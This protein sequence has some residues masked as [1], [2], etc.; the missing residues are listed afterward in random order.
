MWLRCK[1]REK[2]LNQNLA[3]QQERYNVLNQR[4][5]DQQ[6]RYNVLQ[7]EF[8]QF[9]SDTRKE[10]RLLFQLREILS[11][12]NQRLEPLSRQDKDGVILKYFLRLQIVGCHPQAF[13]FVYCV[14]NQVVRQICLIAANISVGDCLSFRWQ[15]LNLS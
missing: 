15:R 6:E 3:D 11:E 5:A 2:K 4:L 12:V 13:L 8:K 14:K 10:K 7:N 1:D 9:K